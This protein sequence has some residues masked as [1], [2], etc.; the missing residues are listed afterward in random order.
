MPSPVVEKLKK[1]IS[2]IEKGSLVEKNNIF[3]STGS[4]EVDRIFPAN[5][6]ESSSLI[7]VL[8]ESYRQRSAAMGAALAL[9]ARL[10][11]QK[12]GPL[13]WCQLR[14]PERLHLHAPGL[15][16]FG[17]DPQ[18]IVKLTIKNEQDLLWAMEEALDCPYLCGVVGVLWKEKL[19][20]FTASRRLSLR[21]RESGVSALMLRSHRANG[22]TAADIRLSVSA[23][24]SSEMPPR[25][26]FLPRIGKTIW[27]LELKKCRG[28]RSGSWQIGWN[29]ET[30]S[31]DLASQLAGRAPLPEST[32]SSPHRYTG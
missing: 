30:V 18:R 15:M 12:P 26:V 23:K 21:A 2:A 16:A 8:P 29:H 22:T 10:L 24:I 7:E 27:N 14:D 9:S 4:H 3:L 6:I 19:Y 13:I 31:F 5:S 20:N 11:H 28:A 17:I 25:K 1:Q 32:A